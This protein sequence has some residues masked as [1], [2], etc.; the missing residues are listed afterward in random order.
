MMTKMRR[1]KK[2]MMMTSK[3]IY[4]QR[5]GMGNINK[6]NGMEGGCRWIK[7]IGGLQKILLFQWV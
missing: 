5:N 1:K 2:R 7:T 6:C 4:K 3:A